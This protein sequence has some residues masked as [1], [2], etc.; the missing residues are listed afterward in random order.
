MRPGPSIERMA[1]TGVRGGGFGT[2]SDESPR[3]SSPSVVARRLKQMLVE[4]RPRRRTCQTLRELGCAA[5]RSL[6]VKSE[7]R[8][9]IPAASDPS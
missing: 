3:P 1:R 8:G 5:D 2:R 6:D 9:T 7:T 4:S